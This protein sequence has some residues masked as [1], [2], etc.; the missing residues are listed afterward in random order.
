MRKFILIAALLLINRMIFSTENP[1]STRIYNINITYGYASG[2][3]IGIGNV[4]QFG[5]KT[6]EFTY[7]F[8]YLKNSDYFVTGIYCQINS[9]RNKQRTGFFTLLMAGV[10]YIKGKERISSIIGDPGGPDEEDDDKVKFAGIH[11][12][13]TIGCGSSFWISPKNRL[14]FYL[15]LGVKATFASLNLAVTF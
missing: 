5:K 8:H 15:D 1:D 11:P 9:Y 14:L 10:D 3:V 7:N 13:L 2:G 6:K 4:K 12:I